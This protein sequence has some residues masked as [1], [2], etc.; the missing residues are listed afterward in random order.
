MS[1]RQHSETARLHYSITMFI[2]PYVRY[3]IAAII[4]QHS[5]FVYPF[6]HRNL[7]QH[8]HTELS[9]TWIMI[10]LFVVVLILPTSHHHRNNVSLVRIIIW[11]R[12]PPIILLLH[13]ITAIINQNASIRTKTLHPYT[14]LQ[15]LMIVCKWMPKCLISTCLRSSVVSPSKSISLQPEQ[16][17]FAPTSYTSRNWTRDGGNKDILQESR[18]TFGHWSLR[19]GQLKLLI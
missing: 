18:Y 17:L 11:S 16:S 9:A 19:P 8:I 15:Q 1:N 4:W 14:I 13:P 6:H 12:S 5:K 7:Q 3:D 2:L 10:N